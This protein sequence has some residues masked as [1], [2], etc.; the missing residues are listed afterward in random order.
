MVEN[1]DKPQL[2]KIERMKQRQKKLTSDIRKEENKLKSQDRKDDTR[3]KII[4][5]ALV[6]AHMEKD[7]E[8]KA[9]CERLQREG[10]K[11]DTDRELFSLSPLEMKKDK[12]E[13]KN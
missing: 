8:F 4:M 13:S 5:G 12:E 1:T 3:R 10:I 9:I 2:T 7:A 6:F 11:S